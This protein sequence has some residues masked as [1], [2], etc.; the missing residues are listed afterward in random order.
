MSLE[1]PLDEVDETLTLSSVLKL[2][3]QNSRLKT[4]T[5]IALAVLRWPLPW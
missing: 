2:T 4:Q 1:S 3:T 5:A